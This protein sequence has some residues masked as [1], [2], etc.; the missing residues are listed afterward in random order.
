V[1]GAW[2]EV[3]RLGA[4]ATERSALRRWARFCDTIGIEPR[5]VSDAEVEAFR[6]MMEAQQSSKD[7]TRIIGDLIRLWN[8]LADARPQLDL[9]SELT[10]LRD[11]DDRL[12]EDELIALCILLLF[13]GHETTTNHLANGMAALMRFPDQMA[14][15]RA[16]PVITSSAIEELLRYTNPVQHVAPRYALEDVEI[17]GVKIAQGSTVML[18]IAAANYDPDMFPNPDQLDITRNPNRHVALGFG[19][20]Y[21]VGAP[22]A[23]LE[24]K[25]AFEVLLR[26]YPHMQLAAAPETLKWHGVPALRGLDKLPIQLNG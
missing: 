15:W 24:G 26:R 21:C 19:V 11:G 25:I 7:P 12:S 23:R 14:R 8:R 17:G 18:G 1:S 13:A 10:H 3:A 20:H 6:D 9:L 16:D 5:D 2:A 22:L 4:N